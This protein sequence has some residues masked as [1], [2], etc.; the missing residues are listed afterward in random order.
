MVIRSLHFGQLCSLSWGS[1]CVFDEARAALTKR[2]RVASDAILKKKVESW[3]R[4]APL[5]IISSLQCWDKAWDL[6]CA[7]RVPASLPQQQLNG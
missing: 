4:L 2:V 7:H 5:L 1:V 6:V 3:F